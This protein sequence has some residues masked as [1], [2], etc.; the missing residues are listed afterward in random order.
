MKCIR[1]YELKVVRSAAGFYIGTE[2]A[3]NQNCPEALF[4]YCR[5]SDYMNE[6]QAENTVSSKKQ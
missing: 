2:V 6:S 3:V 5:F 4:P 1:G